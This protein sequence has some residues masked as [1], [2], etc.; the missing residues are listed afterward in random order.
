MTHQQTQTALAMIRCG[1]SFE[2]AAQASGISVEDITAMWSGSKDNDMTTPTPTTGIDL[3]GLESAA[4]AAAGAT[5]SGFTTHP[6]IADF[7]RAFTPATALSLISALRASQQVAKEQAETIGE[8]VRAGEALLDSID[9]TDPLQWGCSTVAYSDFQSAI[10][11]AR[12]R[13]S[14]GDADGEVA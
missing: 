3:D 8:L 9:L 5:V 7:E 13:P 14:G 1:R 10:L 2:E 11:K 4:R 6:K 12:T